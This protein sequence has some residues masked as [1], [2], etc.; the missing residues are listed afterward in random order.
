VGV[1]DR[2][3]D[4]G[5]G[6]QGGEEGFMSPGVSPWGYIYDDKGGYAFREMKRSIHRGLPAHRMA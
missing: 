1:I 5:E 2:D 3:E 4:V 6:G